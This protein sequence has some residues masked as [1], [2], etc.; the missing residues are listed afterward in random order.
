MTLLTSRHI[1]PLFISC[2][3]RQWMCCYDNRFTWWRR[4]RKVCWTWQNDCR[5]L[6][7]PLNRR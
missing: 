6:L 7:Q 2:W 4:S 5:T 3:G 1:G